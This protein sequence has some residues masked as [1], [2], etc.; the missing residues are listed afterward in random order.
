MSQEAEIL[1]RFSNSKTKVVVVDGP[2]RMICTGRGPKYVFWEEKRH[3]TLYSAVI[4]LARCNSYD[5]NFDNPNVV[6]VRR[7]SPLASWVTSATQNMC[8]KL[9]FFLKILSREP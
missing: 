6:P 5:T 9:I 2:N 1:I 4:N 3:P 8:V 7:R